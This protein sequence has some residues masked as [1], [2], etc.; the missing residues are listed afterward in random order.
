MLQQKN[1]EMADMANVATKLAA[2]LQETKV[3]KQ[4]VNAAYQKLAEASKAVVTAE[5]VLLSALTA[6]EALTKEG[7][8]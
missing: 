1:R 7:R 3:A 4:E 2:L 5:R 8:T 6:V